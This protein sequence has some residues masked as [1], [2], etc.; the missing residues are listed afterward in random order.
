M[1]DFSLTAFVSILFLVDPPR[2]QGLGGGGYCG[3]QRRTPGFTRG[4]FDV[5]ASGR[6]AGGNRI[7]TKQVLIYG[8]T[9]ERA[10]YVVVTVPDSLRMRSPVQDGPKNLRGNYYLVAVPA[11]IGRGARINWLDEN[12]KPGSRG[13]VLFPPVTGKR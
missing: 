2:Q 1:L 6:M 3:D 4:Q 7:R 11:H 9:P 8:R 13:N 12:E 5:P 10:K